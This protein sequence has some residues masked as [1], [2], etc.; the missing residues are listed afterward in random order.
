[1]SPLSI[2]PGG[3]GLNVNVDVHVHV[4]VKDKNEQD[5]GEQYA[6]ASRM[7]VCVLT[8]LLFAVEVSDVVCHAQHSDGDD[9]PDVGCRVQH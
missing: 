7:C 1:M 8:R 5:A 2:V 4:H 9:S 3:G 6:V